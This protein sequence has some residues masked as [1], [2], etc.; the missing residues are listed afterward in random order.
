MASKPIITIGDL[1]GAG[2]MSDIAASYHGRPTAAAGRGVSG[3]EAPLLGGFRPS[4]GEI[5][6][7]IQ[8]ARSS[9]IVSGSG[10]CS[11]G[12]FSE[13]QA[14]ARLALTFL[15][16]YVEQVRM[17]ILKRW[18]DLALFCQKRC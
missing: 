8:V 13:Y 18:R 14:R 12:R 9:C 3:G 15:P 6:P 10:C 5:D 2:R 17:D 11:Y 1:G 7:N 4:Q 16:S